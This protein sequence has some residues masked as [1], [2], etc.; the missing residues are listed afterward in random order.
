MAQWWQESPSHIKTQHYKEATP[1]KDKKQDP[2]LLEL[3]GVF[4]P[5][6]L[7]GQNRNDAGEP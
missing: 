1:S 3:L 6:R 7:E 2:E 5:F 4:T